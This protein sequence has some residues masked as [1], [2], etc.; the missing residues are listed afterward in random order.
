M[1]IVDVSIISNSSS[2]ATSKW[3][4]LRTWEDSV[5][6]VGSSVVGVTSISCFSSA[7]A[8]SEWSVGSVGASYSSF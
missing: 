8:P 6:C 3:D 7:R 5:V 4:V 2:V 1:F